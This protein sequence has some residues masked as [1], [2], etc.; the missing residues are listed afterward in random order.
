MSVRLR[1]CNC[2]AVKA[3]TAI[4]TFWMFFE[5]R[6]AVTTT[7]CSSALLGAAAD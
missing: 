4:G 6:S 2:S 3:D 7:S 5:R 1:L